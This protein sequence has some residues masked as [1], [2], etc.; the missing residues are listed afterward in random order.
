MTDYLLD[1]IR[2]LAHNYS[3]NRISEEKVENII[4]TYSM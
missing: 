3:G 1:E 2:S 4:A